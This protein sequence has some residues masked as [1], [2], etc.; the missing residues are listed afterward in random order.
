MWLPKDCDRIWRGSYKGKDW[1]HLVR[2][3]KFHTCMHGHIGQQEP[4]GRSL[5]GLHPLIRSKHQNVDGSLV[6]WVQ[7]DGA[8]EPKKKSGR[9]VK[10]SGGHNKQPSIAASLDAAGAGDHKVMMIHRCVECITCWC[11]DGGSFQCAQLGT[12]F[13]GSGAG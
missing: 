1:R 7:G 11:I 13:A 6:Y 9:K 3:S 8:W 5:Q 10:P 4:A 2:S 12:Q